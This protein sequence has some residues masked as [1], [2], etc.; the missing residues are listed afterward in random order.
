M[1]NE[2]LSEA[3]IERRAKAALETLGEKGINE[4]LSTFD[5]YGKIA[6]DGGAVKKKPS[7]TTK[8]ELARMV[9]TANRNGIDCIVT[10]EMGKKDYEEKAQALTKRVMSS[11][12]VKLSSKAIYAKILNA[13]KSSES[14]AR[15][16]ELADRL[17]EIMRKHHYSGEPFGTAMALLKD[18]TATF[19]ADGGS[20][21]AFEGEEFVG[22]LLEV[23]VYYQTEIAFDA[24]R[25]LTIRWACPAMA[26][27]RLK[28][29]R[30]FIRTLS[31]AGACAKR[32]GS[33]TL[34]KW[35]AA[36]I[37]ICK[38]THTDEK[39]RLVK[40][41]TDRAWTRDE[42]ERMMTLFASARE[43]MFADS[44]IKQHEEGSDA[45]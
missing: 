7:A 10:L 34:G 25:K 15:Q 3:E 43:E 44:C 8:K 38:I 18:I 4:F 9:E 28:F 17:R 13:L 41:G 22:E 19:D 29:L 32:L 36:I 23:D 2:V 14:K 24:N 21:W 31:A 33:A 45:E 16:T 6:A 27:A 39:G 11:K 5:D 37:D 40:G 30:E 12:V 1:S 35:R 42:A 20:L 26:R